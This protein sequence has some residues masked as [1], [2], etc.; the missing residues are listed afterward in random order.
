MPL[1]QLLTSLAADAPQLYSG[2]ESLVKAIVGHPTPS[3]ALSKASAAVFGLEMDALE[4]ASDAAVNEALK[5]A[6]K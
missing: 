3:A 6:H 4:D 2:I 5:L 1:I